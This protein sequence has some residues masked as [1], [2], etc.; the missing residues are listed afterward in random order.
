MPSIWKKLT[1]FIVLATQLPSCKTLIQPILTARVATG[2]P[3]D[4]ENGSKN[5]YAERTD[6][7]SSGNWTLVEALVGS[8]AN[9]AKNGTKAVRI[10]DSGALRMAFDVTG[11]REV[12]VSHGVYG[13]DVDT[14]WELWYSTNSGGT[15]QRTGSKQKTAGNTL[16]KVSFLMDLTKARF[17]IR[18]INSDGSRLNIDDFTIKNVT[19]ADFGQAT[20]DDNLGMGNP[21]G[22]GKGENNFLM[23]KPQ[24]VLSYNRTRGTANWSSWHLSTAW[25]G[26]FART[27]AFKTDES[28]PSTWYK[29]KPTDYSLSGFDR[30]HLCPSDDRDASLIDNE[31]TFLMTNMVPQAPG[32][33]RGPWKDLEEYTRKLVAAGNEAYV[34]AGVNGEWGVGTEGRKKYLAAENITIPETIWKVIV[35]LP[36]GS[37]DASRVDATTRVIAVAMP[38]KENV[39]GTSW[40]DYR[41]NVDELETLTGY[42]FLSNV[43]PNIQK[44]IQRKKDDGPTVKISLMRN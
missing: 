23:V 20:R 39:S 17:E 44:V 32:N 21:S 37:N 18:K 28:L 34:V 12:I 5:T 24:Y 36:L 22:A 33:N 40:G 6:E 3:E 41:V 1:L 19:T 11:V 38:N 30:G 15:W 31:A 43:S 29:V 26:D 7:F 42:D 25:K 16:K 35:I 4:F 14:E 27:D 9:D 13:T 2:F 10:K 8:N